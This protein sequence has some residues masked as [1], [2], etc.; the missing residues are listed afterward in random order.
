LRK[1]QLFT[2]LIFLIGA[3]GY[4]IYQKLTENYDIGYRSDLKL[5]KYITVGLPKELFFAEEKVPLDDPKTASRLSHELE[6]QTYQNPN[7]AQMIQRANYWLPRIDSI[8]KKNKIPSD[9]KYLALV[10]SNLINIESPMGAAGF[11]QLLPTTATE[12]GLE[13]ND[14]VD[15]R[16]NALKATKAACKYLQEGFKHLHNW[17][18]VAASYNSGISYLYN[19]HIRQRQKSVYKMRL[20]YQ[21]DGYIYRIL[22]F[23]QLIEHQKE[24]GYQIEDDPIWNVKKKELKITTSVANLSVFI[25]NFNVSYYEM[26]VYNPWLKGNRLTISKKGKNY[27]LLIP[28]K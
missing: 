1:I 19:E 8:L 28:A 13:I 17:T 5:N 23:K 21:T 10:E 24:Y 7:M 16:Y 12:M 3:I 15:E 22:A 18:S 2:A 4:V 27:K 6:I 9:F 20:N 14:E 25:K 11:W 26:K